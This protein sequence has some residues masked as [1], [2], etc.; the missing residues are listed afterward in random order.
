VVISASR[1]FAVPLGEQFALRDLQDA[2]GFRPTIFFNEVLLGCYAS[3]QKRE[4]VLI[5]LI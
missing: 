2:N 3:D 1:P 4:T 5:Y